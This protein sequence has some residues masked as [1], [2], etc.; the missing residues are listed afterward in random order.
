MQHLADRADGQ[1]QRDAAGQAGRNESRDGGVK[2]GQRQ[3]QPEDAEDRVE[4]SLGQPEAD[5]RQRIVGGALML[6]SVTVARKSAG[7]A[8]RLAATQ[9]PWRRFG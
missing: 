1:H 7:T 8:S 3:G 9:A 4:N 2:R 6:S 5:V